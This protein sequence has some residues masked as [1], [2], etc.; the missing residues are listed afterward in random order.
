MADLLTQLGE[1][2]GGRYDMERELGRGG[3]NGLSR[4]RPQASAPS[5][6]EGPERGA[7]RSAWGPLQYMPPEQATGDQTLDMES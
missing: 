2:L 3:G 4:A 5:R 7:R 6:R 1:L